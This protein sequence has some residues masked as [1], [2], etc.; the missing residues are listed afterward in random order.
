MDERDLMLPVEAVEHGRQASAMSGQSSE[1]QTWRIDIV[2]DRHE[3]FG[4]IAGRHVPLEHD[5]RW[6]WAE[7]IDP[8]REWRGGVQQ[9]ASPELTEMRN[10]HPLGAR[11]GQQPSTVLHPG[12]ALLERER[13]SLRDIFELQ[14]EEAQERCSLG[15][16][17]MRKWNDVHHAGGLPMRPS[18]RAGVTS[19]VATRSHRERSWRAIRLRA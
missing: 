6:A 18:G 7:L 11:E 12:R 16:R 10:R 9:R 17:T 2:E 8:A 4:R 1:D 15:A 3:A 14:I 13:A 5:L 19:Q